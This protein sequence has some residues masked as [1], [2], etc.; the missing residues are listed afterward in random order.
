METNPDKIKDK[1]FESIDPNSDYSHEDFM[2]EFGGNTNTTNETV[3][4]KTQIKFVNKST[5]ESP[6]YASDGASGFDFRANLPDGSVLLEGGAFR[7]IPTGLYFELPPNM[8]IQ[9]RP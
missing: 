6:K 4:F 2:K 9:V 8:E 1:L 5:N 7:I 3:S